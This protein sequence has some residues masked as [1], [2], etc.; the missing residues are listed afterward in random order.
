MKKSLADTMLGP[1]PT[2]DDAAALLAY[3]QSMETP[4]NPFRGSGSLSAAAERGKQIFET[5][6]AACAT[7]HSGPHFTDGRIHDVGLGSPR[8]RY[9]GYN[10]PSLR[11]VYQKVKL[12][13]DGRADS[14]RD[15]LTG[16]HA[17][18]NVAGSGKL[19]DDELS[20][21]LEYLKT[22]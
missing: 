16:P 10:T 5:E 7:C 13:H 22:L 14:L 2:D 15:V 17:P 6:K 21:L 19:S 8:D 1:P 20:D 12:L 11:G 18:E 9:Q 4:P 3:L